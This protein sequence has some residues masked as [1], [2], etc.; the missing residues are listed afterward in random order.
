[1]R[2]FLGKA[3]DNV[4]NNNLGRSE[5]AISRVNQG[6]QVLPFVNTD[7][8]NMTFGKVIVADS[9]NEGG[10]L[11]P[12]SSG[13]NGQMVV[14]QETRQAIDVSGTVAIQPGQA[15]SAVKLGFVIVK[16]VYG[17]PAPKGQVYY[18]YALGN[19]GSATRAVGT[20]EAAAVSNEVIALPGA[21][22]EGFADASGLVEIS[23]NSPA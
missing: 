17:S 2:K 6:S 20:I 21:F 3:H 18:R 10:A 22:F 19:T 11:I 4:I 14:A 8:A 23:L 9:A 1:M 15:G 7:V 16:C 13:D 5:G 12:S